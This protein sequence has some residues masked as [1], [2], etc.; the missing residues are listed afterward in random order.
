MGTGTGLSFLR[1]KSTNKAE[2]QKFMY[3]NSG[4]NTHRQVCQ[5]DLFGNYI[6]THNCTSD[7]VEYARFKGG[8]TKGSASIDHSR[9]YRT[10]TLCLKHKYASAYG[11]VWIYLD[12]L[13]FLP[14]SKICVPSHSSWTVE[15]ILIN[16]EQ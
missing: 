1:K 8:S 4:F 3:E 14:P 2:L 7:A 12:E 5:Y 6:T 13:N 15:S 9:V 10:M 11:F 16:N